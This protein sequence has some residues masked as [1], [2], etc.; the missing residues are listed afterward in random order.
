MIFPIYN[1]MDSSR[2]SKSVSAARW[3]PTTLTCLQRWLWE[4]SA[5]KTRAISGFITGKRKWINMSTC[6]VRLYFILL[7]RND[8]CFYIFIYFRWKKPRHSHR[9]ELLSELLFILL[10]PRRIGCPNS[11]QANPPGCDR[12]SRPHRPTQR[13]RH[14]CRRT[15]KT[16]NTIWNIHSY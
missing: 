13:G 6:S 3:T 5:T 9:Q 15:V 11:M 4:I 14:L 10:P 12:F 7:N 16:S 1:V 2:K 8:D